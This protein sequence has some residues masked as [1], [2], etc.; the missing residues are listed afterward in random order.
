MTSRLRA[1]DLVEVR[2]VDEIVATL[3]ELARLDGLPF[4]PEAARFCGRRFRVQ[5]RAHKT[6]ETAYA[7]GFR[8]VRDT[9]HLAELRCDG[10]AHGGCQAACLLFWKEAW[11]K[12]VAEPATSEPTVESSARE[13]VP[14]TVAIPAPVQ[15]GTQ[16]STVGAASEPTYSC[17]ATEL[18]NATSPLRWWDV[19]QYAED[20]SS[21]NV[22]PKRL[23]RGLAIILFNK[24]QAANAR[25]SPRL[26]LVKGARRYPFVS[27]KLN[28]PTPEG[29]LNLQPGEL[30]RIKSKAEIE[31]TLNRKNRNRGLSFDGNMSPYCGRTARVR[32]TV[33]KIIDERTGEMTHFSNE[34]VLLE[35]VVCT[36]DYMQF[37]PRR[38]Y[39]YWR[40]LWL[41]RV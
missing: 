26:T 14:T 32:A 33:T 31:R 39:P 25:F 2:S 9:V 18:R 35:G 27:G 40:E 1:G 23:L 38:I 16:G 19:R 17:Q 30:V 3:D 28:G 4:M 13:E 34:C 7:T 24:F 36:G 15:R 29:R 8:R 10:S 12:R 37:C 5:S 41:E 20:V 22:A 11:L 6:C 21:G